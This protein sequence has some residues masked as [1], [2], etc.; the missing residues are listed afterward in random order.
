MIPVEHLPSFRNPRD[1][2]LMNPLQR[3]TTGRNPTLNT[4]EEHRL[5]L[6]HEVNSRSSTQLQLT[7]TNWHNRVFNMRTKCENDNLINT[8]R[9]K[10][11]EKQNSGGLILE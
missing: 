5:G 3:R 1:Y 2:A 6:Q 7:G 8:F 10:W 9:A 11:E 4:S